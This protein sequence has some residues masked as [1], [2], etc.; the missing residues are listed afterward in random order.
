MDNGPIRE[1]QSIFTKIK[2]MYKKV[3]KKPKIENYFVKPYTCE[4]GVRK[5]AELQC[6]IA[7]YGVTAQE[8][9]DGLLH[10]SRVLT[11]NEMRKIM[12]ERN[13]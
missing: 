5:I 10:F 3:F 12:E 7:K 8:F 4:D 1:E 11:P 13:K 6:A 9:S 2:D